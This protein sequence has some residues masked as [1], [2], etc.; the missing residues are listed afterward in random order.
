MALSFRGG[1]GAIPGLLQ[2]KN[3]Q[4][5]HGGPFAGRRSGGSTVGAIGCGRLG[6]AGFRL[7]TPWT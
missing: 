3:C 4:N 7:G 6:A 2:K 5:I 1:G